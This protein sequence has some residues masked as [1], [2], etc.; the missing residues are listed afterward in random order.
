MASLLSVLLV[1]LVGL[2]LGKVDW[3]PEGCKAHMWGQA[4]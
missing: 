2:P 1:A 3:R 4:G